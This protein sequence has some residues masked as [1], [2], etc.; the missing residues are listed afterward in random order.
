MEGLNVRTVS[1]LGHWNPLSQRPAIPLINLKSLS[2]GSTLHQ[3]QQLAALAIVVAHEAIHIALWEPLFT[4]RLT[5]GGEAELRE[6]ML[7]FEAVAFYFT[8]FVSTGAAAEVH[9]YLEKAFRMTAVSDHSL[10]PWQIFGPLKTKPRDILQVYLDLFQSR[11]PR[12]RND[13]FVSQMKHRIGYLNLR[14][15]PAIAQLWWNLSRGSFFEEY[16]GRFCRRGL[17]ALFD[18]RVESVESYSHWFAQSA[19]RQIA[20]LQPV[21]VLAVRRR[22]AVQTRAYFALQL[23]AS[24]STGLLS[25]TP[26]KTW[27]QALDRY[28]TGLED[29][30]TTLASRNFESSIRELDL[31]WDVEIL[32]WARRRKVALTTRHLLNAHDGLTSIDASRK[33]PKRERRILTDVLLKR[34]LNAPPLGMRYPADVRADDHAHLI[35][36]VARLGVLSATD[37]RSELMKPGVREL[38]S[39][40][41]SDLRPSENE[42]QELLFRSD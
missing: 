20:E 30:L 9:P 34:A 29:L 3:A 41:V 13:A 6:A 24:A 17:P 21:G 32:P 28:V 14:S 11:K 37:F 2:T 23:R 16:Q 4:G 7:S 38:W 39:A 26:P 1:Q 5:L 33:L 12:L 18:R 27:T 22:R 25:E 42:F 10:H 35:A 8:D 31:R 19:L 15:R 40:A 36:R